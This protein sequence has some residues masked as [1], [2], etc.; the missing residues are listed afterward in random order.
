ME[1]PVSHGHGGV[2][3]SEV[4]AGAEPMNPAQPTS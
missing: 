2:E 1:I 3:G 4:G